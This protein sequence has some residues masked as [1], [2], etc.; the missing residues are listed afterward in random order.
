MAS[1]LTTKAVTPLLLFC[2]SRLIRYGVLGDYD[3]WN[4]DQGGS[5]GAQ[6]ALVTK[7]GTN[8]IHGSAYEYNRNTFTC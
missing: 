7:S 8:G 4:A 2:R 1:R 3:E 6:V 5:G